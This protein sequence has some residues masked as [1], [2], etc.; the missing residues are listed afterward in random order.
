MSV[1]ER[2][3]LLLTS[4]TALMSPLLFIAGV[5]VSLSNANF[6]DPYWLDLSSKSTV[7]VLFLAPGFAALGAWDAAKWRILMTAAARPWSALL[8]RHLATVAVTTAVTFAVALMALY[9]QVPPTV[10]LPRVDVLALG[11]AVVTAYAAVGFLLG[12]FLSGLVAA[13]LAFGAVWGWVAYTPAIEPFWLR[14]VTGNIGTSCCSLGFELV[15]VALVAPLL[16][17]AA[18]L[19]G[20]LVVLAWPARRRAWLV[21]GIAVA[22]AVIGSASMMSSVGAD[23]VRTRTGEQICREASGTMFCAWPEHESALDEALPSLGGATERLEAAGLRLPST[24]RENQKSRD[25]WSF[26]LA[27]DTPEFWS[28]TLAVSPLDELPPPCTNRNGGVW[29]AGENLALAGAWLATVAGTPPAEAAASQG[30]SLAELRQLRNRDPA[31][32]LAWYQSAESAM[33][34]CEPTT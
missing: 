16:I 2:Q 7:S 25:G 13:P 17:A 26:S 14:N 34:T 3:W 12:R 5:V 1:R 33:H 23:P 19:G 8:V 22:S 15:P 24:L 32:Q 30:A 10:G 21:S 29:P 11:V 6:V 9:T 28:Q 27:A 31:T 4:S 18:L 20:T